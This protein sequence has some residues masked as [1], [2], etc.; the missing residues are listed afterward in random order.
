MAGREWPGISCRVSRSAIGRMLVIVSALRRRRRKT[1]SARRIGRACLAVS[2]ASP[3]DGGFSAC[4]GGGIS[5]E[6][7]NRILHRHHRISNRRQPNRPGVLTTRRLDM[8]SSCGEASTSRGKSRLATATRLTERH[9]LDVLASA[10]CV[11]RR[12]DRGTYSISSFD[13]NRRIPAIISAGLG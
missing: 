3:G 10:S 5:I 2:Y 11:L 4:S 9:M 1:A 6:E 12:K 13:I 8:A 7:S